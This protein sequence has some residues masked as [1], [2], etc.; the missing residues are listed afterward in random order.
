MDFIRIGLIAC[1]I[2]TG[3]YTAKQWAEFEETQRVNAPTTAAAS[4]SPANRDSD[5]PSAP[6]ASLDEELPTLQ[7][8]AP[9]IVSEQSANNNGNIINVQTDTLNLTIS[10]TG[11]DV[12]HAELPQFATSLKDNLGD[13]TLLQQDSQRVYIAQSGLIGQNGNDKASGRALYQSSQNQYQL[14]SGSDQLVV[15]LVQQTAEATITKR[16]TFSRGSYDVE[17]SHIIQNHMDSEWQAALYAQLKRD[18]SEDPGASQSGMGMKPFL[19]A[20]TSTEN[21]PYDKI[22]FKDFNKLEKVSASDTYIAMLQHYFVSAWI[23]PNTEQVDVSTKQT[24]SGFNLIRYTSQLYSVPAK[25]QGEI[26][27]TLYI[28]PKDQYALEE[29]SPGLKLTVD[30]G[31]LW[32]I[33]QPLFWFLTKIHQLVG[34]WGWSIILL[35]VSIKLAFFPLSAA[36]YRSMAKM[37]T[38][39]PKMQAIR[40]NYASD[41]QKQSQEMMALYQ[42]E[43]VNPLG[44]CLPVLIQMP[45]FISLYWVLSESVELRHSPWLGWI[46]D[47]SSMDPFF[48]LPVI[49]GFSMWFQQR[50]NPTPP[51]PMQARI[52][53]FLPIIFTVFFLFFPAGLVLYWVVNNV[54]SI[55]QQWY[56]TRSIEK[57]AS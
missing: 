13:F 47:L 22:K 43:K 40:E 49:M 35:T 15:D 38:L 52:M 6:V 20:A 17:V 42:K 46:Q 36:S 3:L 26:N 54:L 9:A 48:I 5:I 8:A 18:N 32:F 11:G 51:D 56:I 34:N 7:A 14:A 1:I 21:Q 53:Q 19:G 50:L 28:G 55:A 29:L 45:V 41:R 27:A 4:A 30:Y 31:W 39:T 23:P 57:A 12:I 37:R 33:A 2:A 24:Q 25:G 44:G 10:L 16:Y